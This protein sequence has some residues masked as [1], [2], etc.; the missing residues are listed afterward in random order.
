MFAHVI[1]PNGERVAQVDVPAGDPRQPTSDW[2]PN[3]YVTQ[4]QTIP[5]PRNL[6]A[7]PYWIEVGVYEPDSLKRL[8]LS[9][10]G[11]ASVQSSRQAGPNSVRLGPF[12]LAK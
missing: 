1:A 5:L 8:P 3:Q 6:P 10:G 12:V 11:D 2:E 9:I 7:G 4:H